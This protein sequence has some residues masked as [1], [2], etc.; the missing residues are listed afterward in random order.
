MG[1]GPLTLLHLTTPAAWRVALD[2]GTVVTPSLV[3]DGFVHLS[4]PEQVHLPA[5]RLFA[6]RD[7]LLL[8][9]VDPDRLDGEVRF[10]PGVPGDPG[11]MTFPHLYA[12]LPVAAV[13]SVVRYEA[14]E[15]GYAPPPVL[16]GHGDLLARAI[17][18]DRG[19]AARR[20]AAVLPVTG[21]FAALDPRVPSSWEHNSLWL[22]GDVPAEAVRAD[23]LRVLGPD[24]THRAVFD[25]LPPDGLGWEVEEER[26][27]VLGPDVDVAPPGDDVRVVP[28]TSEVM[29]GL[30]G[31]TWR[32]DLPGVGD[33]VVD[34]LLRRE[35]FA[36]AHVRVVDLA[37]L[38]GDGVPVAG[39]QLR[40]DGATAAVEA[41][42][43]DP[44][45]RG[46]GYARALVLD[47]VRRARASGCDLVWLI[48][49]AEDWPRHWYAR[50]GF[51]DVGAR[52]VA[53]SRRG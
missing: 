38:G 37:V 36:D 18:F 2:A 12:P 22:R 15:D 19:L 3:V 24:R 31:P 50:I 51:D 10:E 52:W 53:T 32:R 14:G 16:P 30:W 39:T 44:A 23:A 21:G 43:T 48:A 5:N 28:A 34:D 13:T 40:I 33:A 47:A 20:A 41:V 29:G 46:R 1:R 7:D 35:S 4:A 42:Q 11:S 25:R 6:G 49:R 45:V 9:V 8:L 26:L 27:M 17:A